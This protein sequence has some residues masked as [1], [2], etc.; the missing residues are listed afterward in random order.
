MTLTQ[1]RDE[2]YA[3]ETITDSKEYN[4]SAEFHIQPINFMTDIK[5]QN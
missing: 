1:A 5:E 3:Q 4:Q 2:M